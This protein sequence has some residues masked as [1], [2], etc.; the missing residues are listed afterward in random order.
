MILSYNYW[1]K[2][3][4]VRL[5]SFISSIHTM[6]SILSS[7]ANYGQPTIDRRP[8]ENNSERKRPRPQAHANQWKVLKKQKKKSETTVDISS[9]GVLLRDVD[10]LLK[11]NRQ[12]L[13]CDEVK[14]NR[15]A[16][17]TLPEP[18]T[19]IDLEVTEL[20]STGDGLALPGDGSDRVYVIPFTLPGDTVKA[21][22][23]RH[24]RNS[25]HSITD[26]IKVLAPSPDRDDTLIK[27]PYFASCSGCQF[28]MLPYSKQLLEKKRVIEKAYRNYSGL[29]PHAVPG[30]DATNPSP[31]QYGYRTKLT[32]HFDGPPGMRGKKRKGERPTFEEVPPIGFMAKNMRRILD[33]EDC[34]I[35]TEAVRLGI[36]KERKKV[37]RNI[38]NYRSGA[39]ILLRQSTT[40][41]P[42]HMDGSATQDNDGKHSPSNDSGEAKIIEDLGTHLHEHTYITDHKSPITE[43]VDDF[44]FSSPANAFFQNNNSILPE[45]TSYIRSRILGPANGR[46]NSSSPTMKSADDALPPA[47]IRKLV[48]AY[49]GSGLFTITLSSIFERSIG[50]DVAA[51]SVKSARHNLRLNQ[52]S[53]RRANFMTADASNIFQKLS[54]S[55]ASSLPASS[56]P[57][58]SQSPWLSA[59]PSQRAPRLPN[60]ADNATDTASDAPPSKFDFNPEETAV[61]IDPPRKGCDLPFLKQLLEFGPARIVYMSCNVHSQ[62]RDIGVLVGGLDKYHKR[63]KESPVRDDDFDVDRNREV[64]EKEEQSQRVE[65]GETQ[66]LYVIESIKGFDFFPQTSH[67]EVV[68]IL[69]KRAKS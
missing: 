18:F 54:I 60:P 28:Q 64:G 16:A 29:P 46:T 32:P 19:E 69:Q 5:S 40:R 36:G 48:D 63:D 44:V 55:S 41:L 12:A 49:C 25:K 3:G 26:L 50:I 39:T 27:C 20:S 2:P 33:I 1:K 7:G 42:K 30:I 61:V 15:D 53:P 13:R 35:G 21:K 65:R 38:A 14:E 23:I 59:S 47:R 24:V 37:E 31:R 56:P 10:A 4:Q 51:D 62:A 45:V 67:V 66:G 52:I 58:S 8:R 9:E 22:V 43:Y 11:R 68:A 57:P 17:K 34:P 6:T